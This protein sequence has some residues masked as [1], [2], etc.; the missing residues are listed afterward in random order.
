MAGQ[1]AKKEGERQGDFVG[2]KYL[3]EECLGIGGMG[4]VYRATNVSLGRKV[5]IKLLSKEHTKNEDD[6]LRFLREARAAAAV[7]HP[8]VVDV[9]DVARDDDGTP[10]IVQELLSGED[11]EQHLAGTRDG[12]VSVADALDIMIPVAEAVAAAHAR[13]VVHRDLKPANIYLAREGSKIIPKVLDFGACLYQTVGA[14]SAKE[15]RM[16]IGTPH[17]MAPEQITT[18]KDVDV[19]A[20]VWALGV[21]LY[22]MLAGDTPFEAPDASAVMKLV[23]TQPIPR[24]REVEPA[25]SEGMEAIVERCLERDRARRYANA[26]TVRDALDGLRK[27]VSKAARLRVDT[28][29]EGD[30]LPGV[31][32]PRAR[33]VDSRQEEDSS[34]IPRAPAPAPKGAKLAPAKKRR[35]SSLLNLSAPD[36]E[37]AWEPEPP[38]SLSRPIEAAKAVRTAADVIR[39][40]EEASG[41]KRTGR[42]KPPAPSELSFDETAAVGGDLDLD[43]DLEPPPGTRNGEVP[44]ATNSSLPPVLDPR[45]VANAPR[46][47]PPT[48]PSS[49]P[50]P[51]LGPPASARHPAE[52]SP[53]PKAWTSSTNATFALTIV[54]PAVVA[55]LALRQAPFLTAPLGH[56]MRGDSALASG[57]LAVAALVGAA[58]LATR[59]L[60]TSRSLAMILATGF[61]VLLGIVM[62]IVTFSASETAELEVPPAA[63]AIVP[64]IAPVVP[65]LLGLVAL[66]R[67]RALW[68]SRYER[69]ESLIFAILASVMLLGALELSPVGAIRGLTSPPAAA[70]PAAR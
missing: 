17:Y 31:V 14:L 8:N 5:A 66:L 65:L 30:V 6:V 11:L 50:P 59:A 16:L 27:S 68:L 56:A 2:G 45:S 25:V 64:L 49:R 18:A 7:R 39:E 37:V 28:P 52:A 36:D 34:P 62:I 63:A 4:E 43:L 67:S 9:F 53:A 42:S 54:A 19:R 15:R 20:D 32:M 51:Q 38:A 61:S 47:Q 60:G 10:F 29:G 33:R 41:I 57:G 26:S 24:L 35:G 13:D 48:A 58:V 70:S 40:A 3:L 46:S 69:R 21:I 23:R 22:E 1:A 44:A 55:F 12:K